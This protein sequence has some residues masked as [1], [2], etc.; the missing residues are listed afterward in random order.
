[1]ARYRKDGLTRKHTGGNW[2]LQFRVPEHLKEHPQ[3]GGREIFY[4]SLKTADHS[5]AVRR[6]DQFFK[7][8]G[9]HDREL[10]RL[11]READKRKGKEDHYWETL[12][13]ALA[14]QSADEL[15]VELQAL[16]NLMTELQPDPYGEELS[17]Y[18]IRQL[19]KLRAKEAALERG[20][21]ELQSE[22][23]Q[24][25]EEPHP[26][27]IN[28]KK[29]F[30]LYEQKMIERKRA[31][32]SVARMWPALKRFLEFQNGKDMPMVR[33]RR[34]VVY[35][36]IEYCYKKGYSGS[37]VENDITYFSQC[38]K[39]LQE[40]GYISDA[41]ANPFKEHSF[42]DF[43]EGGSRE[44]FSS[45]QMTKLIKATADDSEIT[46]LMYVGHYTGMRL[47]EIFSARIV[48]LSGITAF[49]V[50]EKGTGKTKAATRIVPVNSKLKK[51]L[52]QLGYKLK[53]GE[54]LAWE[55][56]TSDALGKRFGRIKK[57]VM[58]AEGVLDHA[59]RFTFHSLRHGFASN[60]N[61]AGFPELHIADL[62][63]HSKGSSARTE[64]GKTYIK[65]LPIDRLE[66]MVE[67][68]PGL[69][70]PKV[71]LGP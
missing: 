14:G 64:A 62:T 51:A 11:E 45:D 43:A 28:L 63:G 53:V 66:A 10:E 61:E 42:T 69:P 34:H 46:A 38:F 21:L 54:G 5:E 71:I 30:T 59:N 65:G 16:D 60:L 49:S 17:S 20:L 27:E 55:T 3:I 33:V 4:R 15:K 22:P 67:T 25:V 6:R 35:R 36:F 24:P 9:Y 8:I 32:K 37:T 18:R 56:S 31:D 44:V 7:Q 19:D 23:H 39:Y 50:A 70:E 40:A 12:N 1:M 26:F 47:D 68:I 41:V 52:S 13:Y 58:V 29:A 2:I 48:E 57:A